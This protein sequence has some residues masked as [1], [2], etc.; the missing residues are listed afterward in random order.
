[1]SQLPPQVQVARFKGLGISLANSSCWAY[2]AASPRASR[3]AMRI[4]TA[5]QS[6]HALPSPDGWV[7]LED[8][9]KTPGRLELCFGIHKQDRNRQKSFSLTVACLGVRE[10]NITDFDG[11]GLLLYSPS[12]VAARQYTARLA[13]LRWEESTDRAT[14][15]GALYQAHCGA[16]DDWIPFD[17]YVSLKAVSRGKC[18]CR[19]PGFL[20]RAYAKALRAKGEKPRLILRI[21]SNSKRSTLRVLHFGDSFVVAAK[22]VVVAERKA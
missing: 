4:E 1:M 16:V 18:V 6:A 15:L 11:G 21:G 17:R 8:V 2:D 9:R 19:G 5:I 12:H 10:A 14:V 20:M 7:R 13:E 22:F 3:M